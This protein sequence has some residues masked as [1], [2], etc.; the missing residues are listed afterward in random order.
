MDNI[1]NFTP[2]L[3]FKV[4]FTGVSGIVNI[5]NFGGQLDFSDERD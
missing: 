2:T 4:F 1:A 5:L 3:L